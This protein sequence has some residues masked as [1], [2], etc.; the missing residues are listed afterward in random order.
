MSASKWWG[1][2]AALMAIA[3]ILFFVAAIWGNTA[4]FVSIGVMW[5]II[6]G[7]NLRRVKDPNDMACPVVTEGE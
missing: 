5:F 6:A 2:S 1:L 7:M 4:V 3:G